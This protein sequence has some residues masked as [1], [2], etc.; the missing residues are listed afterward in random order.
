MLATFRSTT[1]IPVPARQPSLKIKEDMNQQVL[2]SINETLAAATGP[3][4]SYGGVTTVKYHG[5]SDYEVRIAE[6]RNDPLDPSHFR[7]R[8]PITLQNEDPEP[9][10]TEPI[11]K[12]TPE[13]EEYWRVPTCVSNWR[14]PA[15]YVIPMDKR[16]G[17]DA[18]RFEQPGLSDKFANYAKALDIASSS[19]NESIA[20]RSMIERQLQQ[21]KKRDEE[22]KMREEARRINEQK[23]QLNKAKN[24][25]EKKID[26]I[27]EEAREQRKRITRKMRSNRALANENGS[28]LSGRDTSAQ[29]PLGVAVT[30]HTVDDEFDAQLFDK[31]GGVD[32]G[33]QDEDNYDVYD[34]PLFANA[35]LKTYVPFGD[36]RKYSETSSKYAVSVEG[37][38]NAQKS[39]LVSGYTVSFKK[40]DKQVPDSRAG[41]FFPTPKDDNDDDD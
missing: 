41:I 29:V 9:I 22:E 36:D 7:N 25:E 31:T 28:M 27:L 21:K 4:K 10:L 32:V 40:G 15:G 11:K 34:K 18:R 17:A 5:E 16:V 24:T 14:N 26:E 33:Y 20:Q 12:L 23:R 6:K 30:T 39:K 8:K 35:E 13:E 2:Q 38:N 1:G 37:D 3:I 19:I